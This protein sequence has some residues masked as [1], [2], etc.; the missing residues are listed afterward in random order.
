MV[1]NRRVMHG[2]MGGSGLLLGYFLFRSRQN[3]FQLQP[4][5]T[6]AVAL[7]DAV[8]LFGNERPHRYTFDAFAACRAKAPGRSKV[9]TAYRGAPFG[10]MDCGED[11]FFLTNQLL[12][13]ADGVGGWRSHGVDPAH[14]S[15]AL[16]RHT[17]DAA[18]EA[19]ERPQGPMALLA[20]GYDRLLRAAEVSAGSSTAALCA[21]A[22]GQQGPVLRTANLGDSGILVV[23]S[24]RPIWR[25][26]ERQHRFNCPFQ[27]AVLPKG[28]R[29][30][31]DMPSSA[32]AEAVSVR[33]GDFVVVGTDGLFDNVFDDEIAAI[34]AAGSPSAEP[35]SP[36][37]EI[38]DSGSDFRGQD[39][40][41][42]AAEKP[43]LPKQAA[44]ALLE[45]ALK[46]AE[47]H[48]DLVPFGVNAQ[49]AGHR[50]SFGGKMD[51]VTVLVARVVDREAPTG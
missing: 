40:G 22:A 43:P 25:A 11:A 27:L 42:D 17:V 19:S 9:D 45:K 21:L 2:I 10:A 32:A 4:A 49:R 29:S 39:G 8:A 34:V 38:S 16:M 7:R 12:G 5:S 51:D 24:G 46:R 6:E 48:N 23:R 50:M 13:V 1:P 14:F 41:L 20:L 18:T 33:P 36:V 44:A 15:N 30:I 37:A 47:S 26:R 3:L 31:S 35:P 28:S